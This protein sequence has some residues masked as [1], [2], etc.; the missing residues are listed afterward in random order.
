VS[1]KFFFGSNSCFV[2]VHFKLSHLTCRNA[3]PK[4]NTVPHIVEAGYREKIYC[5]Y[6]LKCL[7]EKNTALCNVEMLKQVQHDGR[8]CVRRHC[9]VCGNDSRLC[10][11]V[12]NLRGN[13]GRRK[14]PAFA[15]MTGTKSPR[16]PS[17]PRRRES[18][19]LA[20]QF[21]MHPFKKYLQ[22]SQNILFREHFPLPALQR[23]RHS[24]RHQKGVKA[25]NFNTCHNIF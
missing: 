18:P 9:A 22:W 17:F 25:A 6:L 1:V 20:R 5:I 16:V 13:G 12:G 2:W 14:V 24:E 21:E 19:N 10:G 3:S 23:S 7:Y 11:N 15:G 8:G 4:K